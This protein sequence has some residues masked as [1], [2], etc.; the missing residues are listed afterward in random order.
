[1]TKT[2]I[3]FYSKNNMIIMMIIVI[4][5]IICY[6]NFYLKF[7]RSKEMQ[8]NTS[9]KFQKYLN[10]NQGMVQRGENTM[11]FSI[12]AISNIFKGCVKT[13]AYCIHSPLKLMRGK[14]EQ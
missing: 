1:M 9:N 4:T 5:M 12:I 8:N 7:L 14:E 11:A 3:N 10:C 2:M 13:I 6:F